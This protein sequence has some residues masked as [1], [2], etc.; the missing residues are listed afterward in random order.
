MTNVQ[1]ESRLT[2]IEQT[3]F[4]SASKALYKC[5]CGVVK[6]YYINSVKTGNTKSCGC[7]KKEKSIG[8]RTTTHGLS[9]HPLYGTWKTIIQR[10]YK[11]KRREY[12]YY[13]AQGVTV[14]EE[15]RNTPSLFIEWA[16][17]NGWESGMDI[18]KDIK[19]GMVYSPENCSIVTH[20]ENSNNRTTN[21]LIEYLGMIKNIQQWGDHFGI[22]HKIIRT[23]LSR[24]W[25]IEEIFT[26]PVNHRSH[27]PR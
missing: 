25:D 24:G 15:W 17:S 8:A 19:G 16:L 27:A 13:G 12:K 22:G 3:V 1:K 18:D 23:R 7:L 11:K 10:C 9:N 26:T 5:E 6:E 2:F 21:H 20:K 14:C 4:G